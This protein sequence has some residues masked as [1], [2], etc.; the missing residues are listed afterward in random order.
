VAYELRGQFLEAC[1]CRVMCPC[2]SQQDPDENSCT[3]VTAWYVEQGQINGLDV[4]N[5]IAVS[6]S[7]HGGHRHGAK[8][9]VALCIDERATDAQQQ[10]LVDA[11]TGKLGGP[12][13]ELADMTDELGAVQLEPITFTSDGSTTEV[14]V[15]SAVTVAMRLIAGSTNRII[16]VADGGLATVLGSPAEVGSSTRFRL[17]VEGEAFDVD[18]QGRGANRGRFAYLSQDQAPASR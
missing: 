17:D 11:F 18:L 9:R 16:S 8:A 4:S 13:R 3:G 2:W 7:H 5:L 10:A 15:G 12:L 1:D 14:V 6:V